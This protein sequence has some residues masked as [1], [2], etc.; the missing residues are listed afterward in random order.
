MT[1]RIPLAFAALALTAC[2]TSQAKVPPAA[3]PAL[4]KAYDA[5]TTVYL[6]GTIHALPAATKWQSA[7]IDSAMAKSDLLVL[8]VANLRD[9]AKIA[10]AF[11]ALAT[12]PNLPPIL[13]RVPAAKRAALQAE[14][15]QAKLTVADANGLKTWAVVLALAGVTLQK[16]GAERDAGVEHVVQDAFDARHKPVEGLE[17]ADQQFGFF[18]HLS[19]D[20]QRKLLVSTLDP[21]AKVQAEFA[22]MIAAW[23]AGDVKRIAASFD[24]ELKDS[25]ELTDALLKHRNAAWADWVTRR[26]ASPGTVFIA[27]GAGHLAGAGS[28][29]ALLAKRGVKIVRVQ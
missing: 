15:D 9:T 23:S 27:V 21:D 4:W 17:T 2:S 24:E 10:S 5:D 26:M 25:P 13:D 20:A 16:L 22:R 28:V 1:S 18:D 14:L 29:E 11:R 8:E 6:F 19:E 3:H 12:A 7:A